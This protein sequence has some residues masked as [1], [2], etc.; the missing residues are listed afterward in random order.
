MKA[1]ARRFKMVR[2]PRWVVIHD[3]VWLC[4]FFIM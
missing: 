3:V 4:V 1:R 2:I